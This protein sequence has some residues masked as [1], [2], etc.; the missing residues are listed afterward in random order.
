MSLL[1]SIVLLNIVKIISSNDNGSLHLHFQDNTRQN[2][3]TNVDI[4]SKGTFLIDVGS[5]NGL[6]DRKVNLSTKCILKSS[7]LNSI[8]GSNLL[9]CVSE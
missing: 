9:Y 4:A 7:K 5:I 2:S 6:K 8:F 3:S 1:K